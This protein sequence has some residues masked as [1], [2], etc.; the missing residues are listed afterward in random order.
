MRQ[1]VKTDKLTLEF[2][3]VRLVLDRVSRVALAEYRTD[4]GEEWLTSSGLDAGDMR[5][6]GAFAQEGMALL[7]PK[8]RHR[9]GRSEVT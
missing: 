5:D 8:R 3:N 9:A 7:K 4:P 6:L 2:G 1:D